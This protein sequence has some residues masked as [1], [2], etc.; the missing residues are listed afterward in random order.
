M[1]VEQNI[2]VVQSVYDAFNARDIE[3]VMASLT[4]DLELVDIT[5]GQTFHGPDGFMQWVQ[6]FAAAA[7]DTTATVTNV[8]ASGDWVFT[9][10]TG[11]GTHAAPLPTPTG[12]LVPM[13]GLLELKFA[14]VF[15]VRDG[16]ISL[17]RAYWV[18]AR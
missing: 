6:P 15:Q 11:R 9:E 4:P 10:H 1:S 7:P 5:T 13:G 14:E 18:P 16:K 3:K 17:L 8:I 2:A 12:D